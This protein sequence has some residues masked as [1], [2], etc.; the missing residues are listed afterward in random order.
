VFPPPPHMQ[1]QVELGVS[2]FGERHR[3][4]HSGKPFA[5][6]QSVVSEG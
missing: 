5:C 6:P 1:R 4:R 3:A 2:G